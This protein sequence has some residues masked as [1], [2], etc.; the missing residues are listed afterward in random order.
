MDL[1]TAWLSLLG[2]GIPPVAGILILDYFVIKK[3]KYEFGEGVKHRFCSVP[4]VVAW[5]AAC[6]VG[7]SVPWGI[8]AV[9]SMVV[10]GIVYIALHAVLKNSDK[11]YIGGTYAEDRRGA[12]EKI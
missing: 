10:A 9:N 2:T 4:A 3:Q 1:F 7:Y 12:L 6:I 8:S 11:L 5:A